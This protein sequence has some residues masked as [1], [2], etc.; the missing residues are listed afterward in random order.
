MKNTTDQKYYASSN[1][2]SSHHESSH[3]ESSHRE[4]SHRESFDN[5]L[6]SQQDTTLE[7]IDL[8]AGDLKNI[9]IQIGT[10]PNPDAENRLVTNL[11]NHVDVTNHVDETNTVLSRLKKKLTDLFFNVHDNFTLDNFGA[12]CFFLFVIGIVIM[13]ITFVSYIATH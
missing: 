7:E 10:E 4:S 11:T 6:I 1:H 9:S 12:V 2:E 3:R 8:V 13:S 5:N